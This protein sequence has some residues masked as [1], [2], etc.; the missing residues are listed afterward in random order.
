MRFSTLN[1]TVLAHSA[2]EA[3]LTATVQAQ[4]AGIEI[5]PSLDST[6]AELLRR[7]SSS[8]GADYNGPLLCL[9]DEQIGG[10]GRRGR[11]WYSPPGA[12]LYWSLL[13][14]FTQTPA[15]LLGL[16]VL[17]AIG[18][19]RALRALGV[20]DVGLKWPNDVLW[21]EQKL[22]GILLESSSTTQTDTHSTFVVSG[23]GLNVA[24]PNSTAIDQAWTD[25]RQILNR[26]VSRNTLAATLLNHIVPLY[27]QVAAYHWP[28]LPALWAEYDS[29]ANQLIQLHTPKYTVQGLAQGINQ[30]GALRLASDQGVRSFSSGEV[31]L[32]RL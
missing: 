4:M 22:A 23:I 10:R 21:H 15:Q 31:S 13:W 30:E 32:R 9:A 25:L 7:V 14:R 26:V 16:S 18:T 29:Y 6:N 1:S 12:N 5:Y 19:A 20:T 28:D 2:I 3:E 27:Q 11:S 8:T 17:T 24:M